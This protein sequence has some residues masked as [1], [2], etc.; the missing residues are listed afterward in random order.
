MAAGEVWG[1][2]QKHIRLCGDLSVEKG[3]R[4][5]PMTSSSTTAA[6]RKQQLLLCYS[7]SLIHTQFLTDRM[8]GLL[9]G[10]QSPSGGSSPGDV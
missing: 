10:V 9:A 8:T 6:F 5:L 2:L 1:L 4:G 7:S 3:V